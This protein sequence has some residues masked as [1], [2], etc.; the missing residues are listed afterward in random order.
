MF[1]WPM[2]M[3]IRET[4]KSYG[5]ECEC[6]KRWWIRAINA[7]YHYQS[8]LSQLLLGKKTYKQNIHEGLKDNELVENSVDV[9]I[10]LV[11]LD[12]KRVSVKY[13]AYKNVKWNN[14]L[15]FIQAFIQRESSLIG[16][17]LW[18]WGAEILLLE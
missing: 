4:G 6:S 16:R 8:S 11:F 10:T 17:I 3:A 5:K 12:P 18:D 2:H 1:H 7:M 14:K 15:L 13:Y 9:I